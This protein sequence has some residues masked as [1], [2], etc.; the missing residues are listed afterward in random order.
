MKLAVGTVQFGMDYGLNDYNS[1]V[2]YEEV[3]KIINYARQKGIRTLDTAPLY[4]NSEKILGEINISNFQVITKTKHFTNS[5][6]TDEDV[7]ELDNDLNKSL[8]N[9][10]KSNIYGLLIHNADDLLKSGAEKLFFHLIKLKKEKKIKK[11]GVSTYDESQIESL[12]N[13][14]DIDLIQLPI[15]ILDRRLIYSGILE[16]LNE[17]QIEIHCRSIFLQGLLL[18]E[19]YRNNKFK[20]WYKLW[21]IWDQWLK[22]NKISALEACVNFAFS[23]KDIS[24]VIVGVETKKQLE[25][26]VIASD[27]IIPEIPSEFYTD[28][29]NLL[30]PNKWSKL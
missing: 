22:D 10:K 8:I 29:V 5:K 21:K 16:K 7:E 23:I 4:G 11:I 14:F 15:N 2:K 24:K 19:D 17:K 30:N 26:I 9:L 25:E 3:K 28:D 6:I 27:I 1:M 18:S 13:K 12:V 20:N